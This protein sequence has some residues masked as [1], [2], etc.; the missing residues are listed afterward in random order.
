[1]GSH[2]TDSERH[3]APLATESA[4]ALP[5][6]RWRGR[7]LADLSLRDETRRCFSPPADRKPW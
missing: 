1:M 3:D 6:R 5:M 7:R 2:R 4:V